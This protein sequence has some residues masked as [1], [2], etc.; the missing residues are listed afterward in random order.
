MVNGALNV[1]LTLVIVVVGF[2]SW[3]LGVEAAEEEEEEEGEEEE[4][5]V[6]E[7]ANSAEPK[8]KKTENYF[9]PTSDVTEA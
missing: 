6:D 2:T 3:M 8:R 4:E 5:R 7:T 1:L 9:E